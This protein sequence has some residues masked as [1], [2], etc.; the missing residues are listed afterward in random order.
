VF[1]RAFDNGIEIQLR[2]HRNFVPIK[3][4]PGREWEWHRSVFSVHVEHQESDLWRLLLARPGV[5]VR[6]LYAI[7]VMPERVVFEVDA[8]AVEKN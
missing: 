6:L 3:H 7:D 1:L 5:V 4:R 2:N 8:V